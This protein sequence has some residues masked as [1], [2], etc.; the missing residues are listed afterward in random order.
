[1]ISYTQGSVINNIMSP[2]T[3]S[4]PLVATLV[5]VPDAL[6]PASA[7]FLMGGVRIGANACVMPA[8]NQ[9][10]CVHAQHVNGAWQALSIQSHGARA[11]AVQVA[12]SPSPSIES[13]QSSGP[14]QASAPVLDTVPAQTPSA[15]VSTAAPGARVE[16]VSVTNRAAFGFG[17]AK[18]AAR[19]APAPRAPSEPRKSAFAMPARPVVPAGSLPAGSMAA[20]S[21]AVQSTSR[22]STPAAAAAPVRPTQPAASAASRSGFGKSATNNLPAVAPISHEGRSMNSRAAFSRAPESHFEGVETLHVSDEPQ[23]P[24]RGT[25]NTQSRPEVL[26]AWCL[27]NA[28]VGVDIPF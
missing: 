9:V 4:F 8:A 1:M 23:L 17:H 11:E 21:T 13:A 6:D 27:D 16:T 26:K 19:P 15:P 12:Q 18:T 14:A 10:V 7:T 3:L 28:E 5:G 2:Q 22:T 20:A 24:P 25:L